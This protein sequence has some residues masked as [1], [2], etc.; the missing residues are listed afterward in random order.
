MLRC[1]LMSSFPPAGWPATSLNHAERNHE[2]PFLPESRRGCR[3]ARRKHRARGYQDARRRDRY[4]LHAVRVQAGRQVRRLRSRPV[5]RD[6]EG[7]GLEIHDPA[8]GFRGPD[9]GA[10]DAEHRRRA[11]R[12]D[13]QGGAQEG[14]RLLRP[15]L[16]QRPRGDGASGQHVDQVDRRPEWQGDRRE[17]GYR[18][19]RLDQGAPGNRRRSVSSRTSTR[20]ISR[21]KP[22]ASTR[23]CTTR[24]TSCSS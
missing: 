13:D 22:A 10:A 7:P 2:S 20:P 11:V 16:R 15:L 9:P 3:R 4:V 14:D 12:D 23:R 17:D 1:G 19:D 21:S 5:G 24:R 8:D 18:D 6:R